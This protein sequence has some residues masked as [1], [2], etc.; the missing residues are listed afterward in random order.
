MKRK[1]K[2]DYIKEDRE[3]FTDPPPRQMGK[4]EEGGEMTQ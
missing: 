3:R 1:K 2:K 4:K